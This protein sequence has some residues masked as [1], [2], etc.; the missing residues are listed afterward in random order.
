METIPTYYEELLTR[1]FAGEATGDEMQVLAR[2]IHDSPR[3]RDLF[4]EYRKTWDIIDR[5]RVDSTIDVDAEWR[6]FESGTGER[7]Q[8][9]TVRIQPFPYRR[10]L[11]IAA[12]FLVIAI[13]SFILYKYLSRPVPKK[14]EAVQGILKSRLP[15]GSAVTLNT[16]ALLE[17][18][19][20]FRRDERDVSLNGE[21]YFMVTHD[22]K[23][24][25]II[26][27]GNIRI[28]VLGTSFYVNTNA[29]SGNVE[30]IL[31]TGKVSLYYE[32][33]PEAGVMLAPGEKAEISKSG[34]QIRKYLNDD[35]NY[36]AWMTGKLVFTNEP[37]GEIVETL[38]RVYHANV[39]LTNEH[40]AGCRVTVTFRD[41][42]L[43]SILNVLK[44][45]LD[46]KILS[47]GSVVE[48][49]GRGCN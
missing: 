30:V 47:A 19:S 34:Q 20:I 1:Y 21:A 42:S 40:L 49:S 31:T 25:F 18:P 48:I 38:N 11:K 12:I 5:N 46:V 41:Q 44:S 32:N 7:G 37:L 17:F 24:P 10:I 13:P 26:H 14:L 33:N 6:K 45:T 3:N 23:R 9:E 39:R 15:D 29:S 8:Q 43:E 22:S 2:W 4:N 36:L 28:G 27:N 16:G 35:G